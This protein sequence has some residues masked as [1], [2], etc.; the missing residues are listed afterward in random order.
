MLEREARKSLSALRWLS[1]VEHTPGT[2][3][4]AVRILVQ[5][6]VRDTFSVDQHNHIARIAADALTAA[7]PGISNDSL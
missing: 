1:L 6:D 2:P 3:Q 5:R 4:T 7:W